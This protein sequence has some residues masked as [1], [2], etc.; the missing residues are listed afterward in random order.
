MLPGFHSSQFTVVV[1]IKQ[2]H[3]HFHQLLLL[4]APTWLLDRGGRHNSPSTSSSTY[5]GNNRYFVHTQAFIQIHVQNMMHVIL[6][7]CK[8]YSAPGRRQPGSQSLLQPHLM[9]S[10]HALDMLLGALPLLV[11]IH[12][13]FL[14]NTNLQG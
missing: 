10:R 7:P 14:L 4:A 6:T 2:Q 1:E 5:I 3:C 13:L 9:S 12:R 11:S 8:N